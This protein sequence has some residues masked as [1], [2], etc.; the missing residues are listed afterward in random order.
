MHECHGSERRF[1]DRTAGQRESGRLI[2]SGAPHRGELHEQIMRMLP[3]DQ[4]PPIQRLA[5]LKD[6]PVSVLAN[7]RWIE[8]QHARECQLAMGR[9][10]TGHPHPPVR[11]HDLG[12]P[13]RASLMIE[14]GEH[15]PVLHELPAVVHGHRHLHVIVL[16]R[17]RPGV[18]GW[19]ALGPP[20]DRHQQRTHR[21]QRQHNPAATK[22]H[23]TLPRTDTPTP[24]H[25]HDAREHVS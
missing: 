17:A 6:L 21:E 5:R 3:V 1:A 19:R 22:R 14:F 8:A 11:N 18:G 10:S 16:S 24:A 23:E 4:R 2:D 20:A 7:R 13:A 15:D 25:R 9:L 12:A